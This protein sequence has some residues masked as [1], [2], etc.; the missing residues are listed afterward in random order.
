MANLQTCSKSWGNMG[1]WEPNGTRLFWD[2]LGFG[3]A[4]VHTIRLIPSLSLAP[5]RLLLRSRAGASQDL[6]PSAVH[7]PASAGS[8]LR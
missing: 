6:R 3:D 7:W 8:D 1:N 4:L 2:V 5:P